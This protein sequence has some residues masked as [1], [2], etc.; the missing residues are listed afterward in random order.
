[1]K[2]AKITGSEVV[3]I[4]LIYMWNLDIFYVFIEYDLR[5]LTGVKTGP[6]SL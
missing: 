4:L 5:P 2:H 6:L 3:F 1:M